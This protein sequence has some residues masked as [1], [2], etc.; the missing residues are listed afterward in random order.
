MEN[1][2]NRIPRKFNR[3]V[4]KSLIDTSAGKAG[5]IYHIYK[6]D[7]GYCGLNTRTGKYYYMFV[8][9]LRNKDISEILEIE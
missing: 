2:S 7:N 9:M 6:N 5:D 8:S 1:K 4:M 3:I